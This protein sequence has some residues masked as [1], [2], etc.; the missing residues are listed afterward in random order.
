[1][2]KVTSQGSV[3]VSSILR[4]IRIKSMKKS[5]TRNEKLKRAKAEDAAC[6]RHTMVTSV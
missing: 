2:L 3:L 4:L 5:E 1:M 6:R